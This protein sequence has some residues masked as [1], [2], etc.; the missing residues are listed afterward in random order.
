M[1]KQAH[2]Y[3]IF[4]KH[5]PPAKVVSTVDLIK[6][7]QDELHNRAKSKEW[8]RPVVFRDE[9]DIVIAVF[10]TDAINAIIRGVEFKGEVK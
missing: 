6:Q 3:L 4:Q 9:D 8:W 2:E 10:A 1:S 7:W 5:A